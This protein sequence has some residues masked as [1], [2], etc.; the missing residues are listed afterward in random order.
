MLTTKTTK[1][2]KNF[3]C[4]DKESSSPLFSKKGAHTILSEFNLN[5]A[6]KSIGELSMSSSSVFAKQTELELTIE[7]A[8]KTELN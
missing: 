2:L 5:S 3:V 8:D 1:E 7:F 6:L 4:L